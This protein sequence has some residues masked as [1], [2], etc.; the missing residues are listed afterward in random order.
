MWDVLNNR[1]ALPHLNDKWKELADSLDWFFAWLDDCEKPGPSLTDGGHRKNDKPQFITYQSW[2][3]MQLSCTSM[4]MVVA[5]YYPTSLPAALQPRPRAF[6]QD[7]AEQFF[8]QIRQGRG[9]NDSDND[10]RSAKIA[11]QFQRNGG[12]TFINSSIGDAKRGNVADGKEFT[13]GNFIRKPT[14]R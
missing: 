4:P 11:I 3:D 7:N 5:Y 8:S 14:T 9:S 1:S 12:S 13:F 6:N 10:A 2:M